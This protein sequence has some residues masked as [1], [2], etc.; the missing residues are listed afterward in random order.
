MQYRCRSTNRIHSNSSAS[1]VVCDCFFLQ[2]I[3]WELWSAA[4]WAHWVSLWWWLLL[5]SNMPPGVAQL[6]PPSGV[7]GTYHAPWPFW[8]WNDGLLQWRQTQ[9]TP[10]AMLQWILCTGPLHLLLVL[11]E[12]T[13]AGCS[14]AGQ[15]PSYGWGESWIKEGSVVH[16]FCCRRIYFDG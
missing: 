10:C 4:S 14:Y 8:Y 12:R 7:F 1:Q 11:L 2:M 6:A 9:P 16:S 15:Y 13:V 3:S 5:I